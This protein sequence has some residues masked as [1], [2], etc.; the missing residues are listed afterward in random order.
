MNELTITLTADEWNQVLDIL[1]DGP[2]KRASPL[3]QKIIQ[4]ARAQQNQGQEAAAQ[5]LPRLQPVS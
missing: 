3:I 2:F 5:G 4:Q 1:G